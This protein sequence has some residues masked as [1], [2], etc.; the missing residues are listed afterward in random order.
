VEGERGRRRKEEGRERSA[1]L[2]CSNVI[3]RV[4]ERDKRTGE[5]TTKQI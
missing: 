1:R 5:R 4:E 3:R 2:A